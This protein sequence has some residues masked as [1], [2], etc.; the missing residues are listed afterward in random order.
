MTYKDCGL[1]LRESDS[2]EADKRIT[3][4]F[5]ERGKVFLT[6]RGV[7][8]P[9]STIASGAR[10]FCY[11]E[12]V[13]FD[14]GGFANITQADAVKQFY[15]ITEDYD[16]LVT[17][18]FLLE[19]TDRMILPSMPA[20]DALRL[21]LLSL[22]RLNNGDLPELISAV[23]VFKLL[24]AEG[25]SPSL[26]CVICGSTEGKYFSGL[27]CLCSSC[28][29]GKD[30]LEAASE[31]FLALGYILGSEIENVY[32]FSLSE[33]GTSC[34]NEMSELFLKAHVEGG[35]KAKSQY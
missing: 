19:L 23:F 24:Q 28:S 21:L 13:V 15:K 30:S 22:N 11:S 29:R 9:K 4:L 5:K 27:G 20:E 33:A 8:K 6:A 35:F 34:L 10:L 31:S 18:C 1:I 2:G 32:K 16:R 7:R 14:G 12:Y 26:N 25:F 17:A 3:V